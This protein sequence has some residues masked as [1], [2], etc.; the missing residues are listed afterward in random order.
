MPTTSVKA[1]L[2]LFFDN[3]GAPLENGQLFFGVVGQNPEV[4]PVPAY[5]DSALTQPAAQPIRTTSGAATKVGTPTNVY[6]GSAYSLTVKNSRG[7]LMYYIA[8]S[9]EYDADIT[10]STSL[11]AVSSTLQAFTTNLA[12]TSNIAYGDALVGVKKSFATAVGRTQH[13]VN[14]ETVSVMDFYNPLSENISVGLQRAID[15][16]KTLT[17]GGA[18]YV[19]P[20]TYIPTTQVVVG[21][22]G[23]NKY[24]TLYSNNDA[25]FDIQNFISSPFL[26]IGTATAQG[27]CN[28]ILRGINAF[29]SNSGNGKFSRARNANGVRFIGNFIH[30]VSQVMDA[31]DSFLVRFEQNHFRSVKEYCFT[32]STA[33][34]GFKSLTNLYYDCC[35]GIAYGSPINLT[36]ASD[37]IVI[38]NNTFEGCRRV[39]V[40]AGGTSISLQKNYMEYFGA[41]TP[42]DSTAITYGFNFSEN[43]INGDNGSGGKY[44]WVMP[45]FQGGKIDNNRVVNIDVTYQSNTFDGSES[46]NSLYN[47][48]LPPVPLRSTTLLNGHTGT[49][50]YTKVNGVVYLD[51]AITS[52]TNGAAIISLPA[53][54]RPTENLN[55]PKYG[56]S[57]Q[58]GLVT[59]DAV[60]GN[61]V[62]TSIHTYI[63]F[64]GL[65]FLART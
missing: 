59:I 62:V 40:F 46:G 54:Y 65:S 33:C 2:P 23:Y 37:N 41:N 21:N 31:S 28:V 24:V 43:W 52:A 30:D 1:P 10:L 56:S 26:D 45:N 15:Y 7:E 58:S 36:V 35:T 64:N 3:F 22:P 51:G 16:V 6:V 61:I 18:V 20:G 17:Y 57:T 25:N 4:S 38:D 53:G 55:I 5:W 27:N 14:E 13:S 19:P 39:M 49:L 63:T 60:N 44:T 50:T 11:T 12:N 9:S 29:S 34:H 48:T 32:S 42:I 47:A 8:D